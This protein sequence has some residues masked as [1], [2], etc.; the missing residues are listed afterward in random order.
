MKCYSFKKVPWWDFWAMKILVLLFSSLIDFMTNNLKT[1]SVLIETQ[2][3]VSCRVWC[4]FHLLHLSKTCFLVTVCAVCVST[5]MFEF[6]FEFI[7]VHVIHNICTHTL[8]NYFFIVQAAGSCSCEERHSVALPL[9]IQL[10]PTG[11]LTASCIS[12]WH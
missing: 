2:I 4:L 7:T 12:V 1:T 10:H 11:I 8:Y 9:E 3:S 5:C 6:S